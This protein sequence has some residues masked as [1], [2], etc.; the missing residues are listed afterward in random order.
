MKHNPE[1]QT[2]YQSLKP[3]Q[4]S[5]FEG[6][7]FECEAEDLFY[8]G[9]VTRTAFEE[10]LKKIEPGRPKQTL[11]KI[12]AQSEITQDLFETLSRYPQD[13]HFMINRIMREM[14][15]EASTRFILKGKR[16]V[17][18]DDQ[19]FL[20][21]GSLSLNISR[22]YIQKITQGLYPYIQ[23]L[24]NDQKDWVGKGYDR[25]HVLSSQADKDVFS[26]I[27]KLFCDIGVK[28]IFSQYMSSEMSLSRIVLH[29]GRSSDQHWNMTF[30]DFEPTPFENLHHD[31]KNAMLKG[32][33]YLNDVTVENGAF[34][35]INGSHFWKQDL[36]ERI[37]GKGISVSNYLRNDKERFSL[38]KLPRSM[39]HSA[40]IGSSI[41]SSKNPLP[42]VELPYISEAG[43]LI[44]F[45]PGGFHRGGIVSRGERISLQIIYKASSNGKIFPFL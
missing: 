2:E 14:L 36:F 23:K 15:I 19:K 32:I 4:H 37:C 26:I 38:L 28:K 3:T 5:W 22:D 17:N 1:S 6:R 21:C 10:L 42:G 20:E 39:H 41:Q 34:S 25:E 18:C 30:A 9:G 12:W 8:L 45:D 27:D 7:L 40:N 13:T 11:D 43:N 35:Y 33:M 44:V 31:P 29:I 16:G 24:K